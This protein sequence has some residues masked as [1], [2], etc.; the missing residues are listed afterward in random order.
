M[1]II[2]DTNRIIAALIKDGASRKIILSGKFT[3]YTVEFGVK[4]V[5]KYRQLI[6]KKAGITDGQLDAVMSSLLSKIIVMN[7]RG[8]A[9]E[10]IFQA[11]KIIGHIDKD[12]VPFIALSL[13]LGKTPVWTDDKHFKAQRA[14]KAL[15]TNRLAKLMQLQG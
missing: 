9:A 15:T 5:K 8:I 13:A 6:K 1:E 3:I 12:D 2:A 10:K 4:E 11:V 7:E 14:I